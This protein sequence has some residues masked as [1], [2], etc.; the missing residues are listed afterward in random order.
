HTWYERAY[1]GALA[2]H[3]ARGGGA[4]PDPRGYA[5]IVITGSARSLVRPEAWMDDASD[6]VARAN[7]AGTPLLGVCFGHQLIG[8]TFGGRVVENP[9]GWE[10]GSHDVEVLDHRDPL[11]DDLPATL[12]V[13]ETHQDMVVAPPRENAAL[14]VIATNAHTPV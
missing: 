9:T 2:L 1:D 10:I 5:G 12:R 11:F 13:N 6:F 7:D 3:D 4:G 14:R 8:R